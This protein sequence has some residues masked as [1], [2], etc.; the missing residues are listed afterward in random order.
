ML[1][2]LAGAFR[3]AGDEEVASIAIAQHDPWPR[4]R[5]NNV[6]AGAQLIVRRR[7]RLPRLG[8]G[9]GRNL[10]LIS[11]LWNVGVFERPTPGWT[12]AGVT[13]KLAPAA[14]ADDIGQ[15]ED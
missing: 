8:F 13:A 6:D 15:V 3:Q 2:D 12:L 11:R 1:G 7:E 4:P 14:R 9:F 5:R 10:G